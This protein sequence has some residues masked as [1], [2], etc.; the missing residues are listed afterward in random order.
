MKKILTQLTLK[1]LFCCSILLGNTIAI[2]AQ[3]GEALH[4]DGVDDYV[5]LGN[6]SATNFGAGDFTI[7]FWIK[8][9][10][11]PAT[12]VGIISKRSMCSCSNFWDAR[13]STSGLFGFEISTA[14][15]SDY[16]TLQT[17]FSINDGQWRHIAFV[18]NNYVGTIY[19]NGIL[20]NT[21]PVVPAN[22]SNSDPVQIGRDACS[23]TQFG[24]YFSGELD[25]VRIWGR[26]LS[27]DEI[28]NNM[29]C[30]LPSG[31]SNLIAYYQFNEGI[32]GG[33]N[34]G[35]AALSDQSSNGNGGT[36][37]N[38]ALNGA[39]SNWVSP[40]GAPSGVVCPYFNAPEITVSGNNIGIANRSVAVSPADNTD[41]GM[42]A[43]GGG[44]VTHTFNIENALGSRELRLDGVPLITIAGRDQADFS[45]TQ[46]VVSSLP[47]GSSTAFDVTFSP[48]A[49][50]L[51]SA[52]V[53]I[54]H[55]DFPENAFVF[56]ISG[57]GQ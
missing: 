6:I 14:G 11:I 20:N 30:E 53:I 17:T 5:D 25:E 46:P 2:F 38:F 8:T 19:I 1:L 23:I 45:I 54:T 29:N 36:L 33:N 56:S 16:N 22:L 26:A 28:L 52:I 41:F 4:F 34:A 3:Q 27:Q 43:I 39:T 10:D 57:A 15:C 31:Q 18:R 9:N 49:P 40:G 50:G 12:T 51:R 42:T 48:S 47:G 7:E 21:S 55:N 35:V 37:L 24:R 32:G 13:M 44:M